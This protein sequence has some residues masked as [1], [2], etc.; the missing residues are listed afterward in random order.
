MNI[1]SF[2]LTRC[3]AK[4]VAKSPPKGTSKFLEKT[5][6]QVKGPLGNGRGWQPVR[7]AV[8]QNG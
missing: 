3:S 6:L 2:L 5:H 8:T 7:K 1:L 4:N